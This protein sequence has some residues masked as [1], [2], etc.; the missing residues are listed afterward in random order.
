MK[1]FEIDEALMACVDQETGE[2]V[3]EEK[4]ESLMV[5]REKK[6]EGVALWIKNLVYETKCMKEEEKKMAERRRVGENKIN[7]LKEW[8]KYATDGNK[9]STPKC[10]VSYKKSESVEIDDMSKIGKDFLVEQA[11]KPDKKAIKSAL[12][13]GVDVGGCHLQ[14]NTNVI[15]K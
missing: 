10:A 15:V 4:L 7:S 9:F 3:D 2:I 5:E 1:I 14:E 13:S 12:K 8:L 11:P 6:I